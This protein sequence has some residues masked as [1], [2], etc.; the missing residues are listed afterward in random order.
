MKINLPLYLH[1]ISLRTLTDLLDIIKD[2]D[3]QKIF[4][5]LYSDMPDSLI[6]QLSKEDIDSITPTYLTYIKSILSKKYQSDL[7]IYP[8]EFNFFKLKTKYFSKYYAIKSF[9]D[10]TVADYE[11]IEHHFINNENLLTIIPEV[12]NVL[13]TE[14]KPKSLL[15]TNF[16]LNIKQNILFKYVKPYKIKKYETVSS[17]NTDI[18]KDYLDANLSLYL[19]LQ[20]IMWQKKLKEGYPDLYNFSDIE[21]DIEEDYDV[22]YT[23]SILE[24]WGVYHWLHLLTN[25]Y[26]IK[27]IS[28]WRKQPIKVFLKEFTYYIHRINE[29]NKQ[30]NGRSRC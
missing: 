28:Y 5:S 24:K 7:L 11:E 27:D 30:N 2:D 3:Y 17:D 6:N 26:S 25:N 19:F 1:E 20:Y 13:I 14:I 8:I 16:I 12:L 23:P 9:E 10:L 4:L 21:E 29:E 15:F 22:E 18:F